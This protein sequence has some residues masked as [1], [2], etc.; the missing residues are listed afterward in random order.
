[1]AVTVCWRGWRRSSVPHPSKLRLQRFKTQLQRTDF[2]FI[3]LQT[4]KIMSVFFILGLHIE[5]GTLVVVDH[6]LDFFDAVGLVN[7]GLL[8][9]VFGTPGG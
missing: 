6:L 2:S 4:L 7:E 5:K 1:M 8:V 3:F 9:A